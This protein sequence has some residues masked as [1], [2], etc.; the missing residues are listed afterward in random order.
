MFD[1]SKLKLNRRGLLTSATVM[2]AGSMLGRVGEAAET[3]AIKNVNLRSSPSTLKI[4]DMR[5][6]VIVKPGPSPCVLIRIDTNQG[7]SGLGEIRDIAGYQYAM[8]LKNRILGENPLNVDYLFEKIAQSGG[9]ARQAGGVCA[10]EM[11]LW[12]IA[13]KVYNC[14]FYQMLGGKWRDTIRIYADTTESMDPKEYGHGQAHRKGG[15]GLC[16]LLVVGFE[17]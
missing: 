14:P 1:Q 13:R 15:L 16:L 9:G 6:A 2:V 7:V 4:T 3:P 8:V 17:S 12:D 11:A 5:Y 10:V